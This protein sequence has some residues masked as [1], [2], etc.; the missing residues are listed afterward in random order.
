[1]ERSNFSMGQELGCNFVID[2]HHRFQ[3]QFFRIMNNGTNDKALSPFLDLEV[4]KMVHLFSS[5]LMKNTR[6][7]DRLKIFWFIGDHRNIEIS[8][9]G[10][11]EGSG[12]RGCG[13]DQKVDIITLF[14]NLDSLL[15]AKFMMFI[16]DDKGEFVIRNL[17]REKSMGSDDN[18]S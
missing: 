12:N 16:D 14:H 9:G 17:V 11:G 5:F 18:L 1:M 2:G 7:L 8:I 10:Q 13:H 3:I 4:D 15:D 6:G